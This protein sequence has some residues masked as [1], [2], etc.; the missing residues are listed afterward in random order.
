MASL[1]PRRGLVTD[2]EM[3]ED[4]L[5][6]PKLSWDQYKTIVSKNKQIRET[7]GSMCMG[8]AGRV[9]PS[10]TVEVEI[11]DEEADKQLIEPLPW[12]NI[13]KIIKIGE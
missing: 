8:M 1:I 7:Y 11:D 3:S 6:S 9:P 12:S 10:D 5:T 4:E 13:K 2:E